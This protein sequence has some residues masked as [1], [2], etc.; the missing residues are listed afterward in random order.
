MSPQ[1]I[2]AAILLTA[3]ATAA[4][5]WRWRTVAAA[6]VC[7]CADR[8][9]GGVLPFAVPERRAPGGHPRRR[10]SCV[11][12]MGD[13]RATR[14]SPPAWSRPSESP[15]SSS[16][17][18]WP[19]RCWRPSAWRRRCGGRRGSPGRRRDARA[20]DRRRRAHQAGGRMPSVASSPWLRPVLAKPARIRRDRVIIDRHRRGLGGDVRR[21]LPRRRAAGLAARPDRARTGRSVAA[22]LPINV[23]GWGP[24]EAVAASAFAILGRG[25]DVVSRRRPRSA[26]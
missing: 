17:W 26:C 1:A 12:R 16:S 4:A 21:G 23:A 13:A 25:I 9:G 10:A 3:A 15:A 2:I 7:D 22:S 5:A 6:S 18:R 24:R 19:R 11:R 8:R 20:G 14:R